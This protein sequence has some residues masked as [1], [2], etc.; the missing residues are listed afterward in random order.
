MLALLLLATL[1]QDAPVVERTPWTW[2]DFPVFVWRQ[3]YAGRELPAELIAPFGGTNVVREEKAEWVRERGHAFYVTSAA[4]RNELHLDA[5]DAW[6]ARV[7]RWIATREPER[8]VRDPCLTDPST[9]AKLEATLDRTYAARGGDHGFGL[10]LGD[11]V[12][13]WPG[14]QPFDG[15]RSPTCETRWQEYARALGLSDEVVTTDRVR[16]DLALDDFSTLGAWLARRR[17]DR[18]ILTETVLRLDDRLPADS[19][20]R[21]GLLGIRPTPAFGGLE[22][23]IVGH[24]GFVEAYPILDAREWYARAARTSVGTVFVQEED[25]DGV[26]WQAWEHWLQGASA[27]VLWSDAHLEDRPRQRDRL[28]RVVESI[29]HIKGSNAELENPDRWSRPGI[30][31]VHDEDSIAASWLRDALLDGA[32]WPRRRPSFQWEHGTYERKLDTWLRLLEDAGLQ[33]SATAIE[34]PLDGFCLLVIPN[35]LVVGE[36]GLSRLSSFLA[37]GSTAVVIDGKLGWVDP[38]GKPRSEDAAQRLRAE[39]PEQV[40]SPP[41]GFDAYREKR[42]GGDVARIR[43]FLAGLCAAVGLDLSSPVRDRSGLPLLVRR[44]LLNPSSHG[45]PQELAQRH[46]LFVVLQNLRTAA[47]RAEHLAPLDL[48]I[49]VTGGRRIE[50]LFPADGKTFR[51]GD[52]AVFELVPASG[53]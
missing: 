36:I 32:T 41:A 1:P 16:S 39:F 30:G 25:A 29:R 15:C 11:E 47:Q 20:T 22:R 31:I 4:G 35:M 37:R 42:I 38:T 9:I 49:D 13:L 14:D 18:R 19:T 33:A 44:H 12:C 34:E 45:E 24:L 43:A 52:A 21:T 46:E 2:N 23:R 8:F 6:N 5:T 27:L 10:S 53:D 26:A 50:W 28:A 40:L 3:R 48:E 17:F 7:E 51:R